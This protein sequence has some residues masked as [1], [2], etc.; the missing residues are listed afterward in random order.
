MQRQDGTVELAMEAYMTIY[1]YK[2]IIEPAEEGGYCV[3]VPTLNNLATQGETIEEAREMA[4]EAITGYLEAL[5]LEGEEPPVEHIADPIPTIE[6]MARPT[7]ETT[8]EVAIP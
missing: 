4:K 8:V 6:T 3:F 5:A 2:V 1:R 7:V